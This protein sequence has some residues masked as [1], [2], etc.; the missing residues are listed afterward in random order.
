MTNPKHHGPHCAGHCEGQAYSSRI[1]ELEGEN[2][3]LRGDAAE[4]EGV[5]RELYEIVDAVAY[6]GVDFGFGK[7]ELDSSHVDKARNLIELT[8]ARGEQQ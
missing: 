4:A 8:R 5:I 6:V 2:D 1:K 7:F 3:R